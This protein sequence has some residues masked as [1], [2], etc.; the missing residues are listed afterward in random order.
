MV[1]LDAS[2]AA[3]A[4]IR[5]DPTGDRVRARLVTESL[6]A[7]DLLDVEVL[8]TCRRIVRSGLLDVR[9]A[10]QALADLDALHLIRT[11]HRLLVPRIWELRDNLSAYDA[12]YVALA[13]ALDAPLV[14]T[15]ARL[16][17]APGIRCDVE[18]LAA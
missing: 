13:E 10:E 7:P 2:A 4:L 14:T 1:V 5:D 9:R 16:A 18:V 6:F 3:V 8:S 17:R 11:P 15:D 12:A